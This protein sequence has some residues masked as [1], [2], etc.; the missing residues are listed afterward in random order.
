MKAL[1]FTLL[2]LL[3]SMI[4][5]ADTQRWPPVDAPETLEFARI[6]TF[7]W[8]APARRM[9]GTPLDID[10]LAQYEIVVKDSRTQHRYTV[11]GTATS[12]EHIIAAVGEHCGVIR[13]IDTDGLASPWSDQACRTIRS[14]PGRITLRLGGAD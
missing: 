12:T 4:A 6:L 3:T 8:D 13:A 7:T 14:G 1:V 10:E 2:I 5:Q 9:N 11:A